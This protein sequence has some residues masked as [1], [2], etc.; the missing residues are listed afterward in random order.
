[1]SIID[2]GEIAIIE[3]IDLQDI[4]EKKR[5]EIN[6]RL[7]KIDEYEDKKRSILISERDERINKRTE[8]SN[9]DK[10]VKNKELQ[11]KK[12]GED[13]V[14]LLK[15]KKKENIVILEKLKPELQVFNEDLQKLKRDL[16]ILKKGKDFDKIENYEYLN[17]KRREWTIIREGV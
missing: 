7:K 1:M 9:L 11:N 2:G 17:E 10:D 6:N 13:F 16:Q 5:F 14:S 3:K 8:Q 12:Y 15:D 4:K